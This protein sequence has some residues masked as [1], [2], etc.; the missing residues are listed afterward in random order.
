MRNCDMRER[1]IYDL[2]VMDKIPN[3]DEND[4]DVK[5]MLGQDIDVWIRVVIYTYK[6]D[7]Q[8]KFFLKDQI[9]RTFIED[10]DGL[11]PIPIYVERAKFIDRGP[12]KDDNIAFSIIPDDSQELKTKQEI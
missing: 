11:P 1:I 10:N 12:T 5:R 4:F 6:L 2:D 3:L 7:K 8:D 9:R